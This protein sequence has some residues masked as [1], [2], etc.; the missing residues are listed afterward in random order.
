MCQ[1][2]HSYVVLVE[3]ATLLSIFK[4]EI[5]WVARKNAVVEFY[6]LV[7][8][9]SA[10]FMIAEVQV[11]GGVPVNFIP[12]AVLENCKGQAGKDEIADVVR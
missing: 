3:G 2:A 12:A 6:A 1:V 7:V 5:V 8:H 11:L 9:E 10:T 4:A